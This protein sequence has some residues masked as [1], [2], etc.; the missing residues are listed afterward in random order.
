MTARPARWV[1][2]TAVLL[3]VAAGAVFLATRPGPVREVTFAA[4][5]DFG[6]SD[7]A[8]GV[9]AG[10]GAGAP[11][12]TLALGDLSYGEPGGEPRWCDLVHEGVGAEHPFQLLAGNHESNGTDGFI[13]DFAACLPSR[14][15]GLV[16]EYGRQWYVDVP[17]EDPV[18][19]FVAISPGLTYPDGEWTYTV[20]S[21]RYRWTEEAITGARAEGVP[22]V[23]VAAHAPCLSIGEHGCQS[24]TDLNDLLLASGVDL[25]LSGHEHLYQ[26][27]SQLALGPDCPTVVPGTFDEDCVVDAGDALVKGAGTVFASVGTGGI[28]QR[29]VYADDP[30]LPFFAATNGQGSEAWGYLEVR[31]TGD[32]L[33]ATFVATEGEFA[34]AFTITPDGGR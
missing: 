18:V 30:D 12:L 6:E 2:G 32:A 23:V 14:L 24:G 34:E 27:T 7:Q 10:I 4:V 21:E 33:A 28:A 1:A 16:G 20:G 29:P 22:W 8:R 11:D 19:R 26:R 5:G 31:V 3:V 9:L 17:Q 15:P 13:D 25:V